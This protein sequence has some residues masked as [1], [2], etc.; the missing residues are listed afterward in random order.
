MERTQ[1]KLDWPD[2]DS[3]VDAHIQAADPAD[4]FP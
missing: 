4:R 3:L 1:D 2:F